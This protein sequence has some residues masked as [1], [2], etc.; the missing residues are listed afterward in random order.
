VFFNSKEIL[1]QL[2]ESVYLEDVLQ[3]LLLE[4]YQE[5]RLINQIVEQLEE[6]VRQHQTVLQKADVSQQEITIK[7]KIFAALG[8]KRIIITKQEV[9]NALSQ[10]SIFS[11]NYLGNILTINNWQ[12]TRPDN[13]WLKIIQIDRSAK[14][15]CNNETQEI[16]LSQ[17]Q[18][19]HE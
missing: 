14:L 7:R 1:Q 4:V 16:N 11:K 17:L 3:N 10:I 9:L 5:E 6:L 8:F 2:I 18:L 19:I 12:S 15:T 13:D